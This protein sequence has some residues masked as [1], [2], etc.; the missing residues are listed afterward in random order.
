MDWRIYL[1][2]LTSKELEGETGTGEEPIA[3]FG[4]AAAAIDLET[5]RLGDRREPSPTPAERRVHLRRSPATEEPLTVSERI[6]LEE[7]EVEVR[8][9][10][11]KLSGRSS[12]PDVPL[13]C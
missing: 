6:R 12:W 4:L 8:E 3:P 13:S 5:G 9:L 11:M 1:P 7:P 10:G 2:A